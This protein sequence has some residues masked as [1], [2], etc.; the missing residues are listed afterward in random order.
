MAGVGK[1]KSL[2]ESFESFERERDG[3]AFYLQA[4]TGDWAPAAPN[5]VGPVTTNG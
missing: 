4:R 2:D 5:N 1:R 3:W